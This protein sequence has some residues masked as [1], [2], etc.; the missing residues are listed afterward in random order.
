[1][2]YVAQT[3]QN[4][5]HRSGHLKYLTIVMLSLFAASSA[6][7]PLYHVYQQ[8]WGFSSAIMT[9]IFAVYALSLLI[10]VLVFGSLSDY[11]GRR[12]IIFLALALEILSLLLFI[13]ATDVRWLIAA[14]ALQGLATGIASSAL[15]AAMLDADIVKGPLVNSIAPFFGLALGALGTSLLVEYAP[16]PLSLCY[17]L[18]LAMFA[19]QMLYLLRFPETVTPQPGVLSTLK[20]KLF[21]P[22]RARGTFLLVM[23][24]DIAFWAL[25]GFF[26]SLA[27]SLLELATGSKSILSGG[28][29]VAAFTVSGAVSI[30]TVRMRPPQSALLI[31]C[32]FLGL[33][34]PVLLLAVNIGSLWIFFFG[35]VVAG[36]GSGASFLGA[37]SLLMPLA[38]PHERAGL[39]ST[40]LALSYLSFSAPALAA[41]FAIKTQG[42]I[43]TTNVYGGVVLILALLALG[44]LL[45]TRTASAR[46]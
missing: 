45:V 32:S 44:R 43:L 1:M 30:S 41:G 16:L 2:S 25:G 21:V 29:A 11:V 3:E 42:L 28:L 46:S 10:A 26:L 38:R 22:T 33:G 13:Y 31:G 6:P 12:P 19:G 27:P 37:L 8:V 7:T 35:A 18:M 20:P 40:F 5:F 36:I 24:A 34:M 4:N 39:M 23:P 14:R 17:I 9:L 15:G